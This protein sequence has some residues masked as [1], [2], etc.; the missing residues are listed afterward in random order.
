MQRSAVLLSGGLDSVV[1]MALELAEGRE[2]WPIQVLAGLAWE[3]AETAAIERVMH[4]EP[5][6]ERVQPVT[7]LQ[8]DM[9][10]VYAPS[11]WAV[12][13]NARAYLDADETVYLEGRN[14]TLIAKAA[15][16]CAGQGI[17]RLV[18]GPLAGNPF[19]DASPAF[20]EAMARAMSIG[21]A[22]PITVAAPL[23][24]L[25]KGAVIRL[26]RDLGVH[27]EDTLSCNGP[28]ETRHCGRCNKCRERR[29]A[30]RDAAVIDP[31]DYVHEWVV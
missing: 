22:H 1:M 18:L 24:H 20:F 10:D 13:G 7:T 23:S 6:V 30:F 2:I 19:P 16:F 28:V 4:S 3:A 17:G 14:I 8:F 15:I 29:E 12:R 25:H 21:L 11:H 31:T 27:F 5:F 26:G 9:R